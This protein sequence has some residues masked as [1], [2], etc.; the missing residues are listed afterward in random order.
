LR[1]VKSDEGTSEHELL[2]DGPRYYLLDS[3]QQLPDVAT[4]LQK[5]YLQL[6][7]QYCSVAAAALHT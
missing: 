4:S 2:L 7:L 6:M 3:L 5:I 1:L